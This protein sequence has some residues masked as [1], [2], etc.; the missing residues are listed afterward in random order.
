MRNSRLSSMGAVAAFISV[1]VSGCASS[2]S[3]NSDDAGSTGS[4][5]R[6]NELKDYAEVLGVDDPPDVTVVR[7]VSPEDQMVAVRDCM[8][9]SGFT[10]SDPD[11]LNLEWE[12]PEG[13]GEAFSLAIYT[14]NAQ[15][16]IAQ[17]FRGA[18]DADGRGV[19]YDHWVD[20]TIPCLESLGY[21]VDT[22][23]SREAF[24]AGAV[25]DPRASTM[26]QVLADV[27]QGRWS[28]EES[29]YGEECP[30]EPE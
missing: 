27:D 1:T 18:L 2:N 10:V 21:S 9:E 11:S 3:D 6:E 19:L 17:E 20:D 16:P 23:P 12:V 14:C 5:E 22:P 25:W 7:E 24:M 4:P 8:A 30:T 26:E 29:V 15:Y 28:T 13:Q